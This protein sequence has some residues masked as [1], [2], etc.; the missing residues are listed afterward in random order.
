MR[1]GH[2]PVNDAQLMGNIKTQWGTLYNQ[3]T[4]GTNV[5]PSFLAALT[6]NESGGDPLA[7]RFEPRVF[8]H[9]GRVFTG[10]EANYGSIIPSDLLRAMI[11]SDPPPE[12]IG[13]SAGY[14]YQFTHTL[15]R[16]EALATS[17]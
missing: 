17:W 4:A 12:P 16:L 10:K 14:V 8:A 6:A 2:K 5:R 9:L 15:Q 7:S 13:T 3:V 1:Q 11:S